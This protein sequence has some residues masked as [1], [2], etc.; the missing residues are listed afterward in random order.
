MHNLLLCQCTYTG[1]IH[2]RQESGDD[3]EEFEELG[4]VH[5]NIEKL[6]TEV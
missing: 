1:L 6:M 4:V 3:E 2:P 5:D